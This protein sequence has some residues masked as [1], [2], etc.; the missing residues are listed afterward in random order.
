MTDKKDAPGKDKTKPG[1]K[2][3][4]ATLNLKATEVKVAQ[5]DKGATKAETGKSKPTSAA[6]SATLKQ[7][8][9][10]DKTQSKAAE[11]Q[12]SDKKQSPASA[13]KKAASQSAPTPKQSGS[14]GG[15]LT[16][17]AAGIV[18]AGLTLLGA[19]TLMPGLSGG[20]S[21]DPS[22]AQDVAAIEKRIA[23]LESAPTNTANNPESAAALAEKLN[24]AE[25]R[26]A[27]FETIAN[28]VDTLSKQQKS[29]SAKAD[30]IAKQVASEPA[31][32]SAEARLASL[33]KQLGIISTAAGTNEDGKASAIPQLAAITGRLADLERTLNNQMAAL[34]DGVAK[35]VEQRISATAEASVAA[36][37]GTERMDRELATVKTDT[38]RFS[39]QLAAT[40]AD[41]KRVTEKLRAVQDETGAVRS[42][43]DNLQGEFASQI[44]KTAKPADIATAV[45]AVTSQIDKLSSKVENVVAT[46]DARSENAKKIVLSLELANLK[47]AL[48][49]GQ[50]YNAELESVKR[51][52]AGSFDLGSLDKYKSEGVPTLPKL[53]NEFRTLAFKIIDAET[54]PA[55]DASLVDQLLAGAKSVVR[56]R[57]TAH[58]ADDE[59][60]EA[61]VGRMGNALQDGELSLVIN[62]AK[63]LP[64]QAAAPAQDWIEQAEALAQV[65]A[66]M[67]QIE[68]QL[69][70]S[71]GQTPST[72]TQ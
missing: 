34:R 54:A 39:Q 25:Q 64:P 40:K 33:E 62:E 50:P 49:R 17:M 30:A 42:N 6:A 57:K 46:E 9:P 58:A 23:A 45:A 53:Q 68:Q 48:L 24:A 44:S 43:L 55:E 5:T 66:T 63:K 52:A 4:H 59:S 26:L 51:A 2:R 56:V 14:S 16:H 29:L 7:S 21:G 22:S 65:N 1:E 70:Q 3:P 12:D 18:G 13:D 35:D 20:Q 27:E 28:T 41:I 71:L 38:A 69:K 61:T 32:E 10:K 47:R 8:S 37:S 19:N 31:P 11:K 60:V 72:T 67:A 36:Q 15:F